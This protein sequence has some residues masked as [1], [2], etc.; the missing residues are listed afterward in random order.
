MF[1]SGSGKS[2]TDLCDE[3]GAG[4]EV[5]RNYR[6]GSRGSLHKAKYLIDCK[7]TTIE[8]REVDSN[9]NVDLD[10]YPLGRFNGVLS[11]KIV[12]PVTYIE[13][14]LLQLI[15]DGELIPEIEIRLSEE[16]FKWIY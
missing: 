4:Y 11:S 10:S 12:K 2:F 8:V 9:G 7:N 15:Y 16:G 13:D 3:Q 14:D 5:K 1:R 6:D